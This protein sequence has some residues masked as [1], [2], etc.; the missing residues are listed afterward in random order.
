MTVVDYSALTASRPHKPLT[1]AITA[2]SGRNNRG[3]ITMRHQGGGHKKIYRVVDFK[4][5]K[6][7]IPGRVETIEYDP[8]RTSFIALIVYRDGERRYILAPKDLSVGEEIIT[9]EKAPLKSGNRLPLKNI[10]VG[11]FVHNVELQRGAGGKL[12]RSAG[13][14]AEVLAH[15]AGYTDLRLPSKELRKVS[16]SGLA[17]IGQ[18]SNAEWGLVNIGKAGRSR[19]LGIRPTVRGSAMNPC[20]H[21]YGGGEGKQR[22]GTKRPKDIWGNITGGHKT[23]NPHKQSNILIIQRRPKVR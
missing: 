1:R 11:F 18:L 15:D 5:D 10:P 4:Q 13:A 17:T 3:I 23:R 22:R 7:D 20:D 8:Y 6:F 19:W 12:L 16:W 14:Q 21:K 9:S 2:K